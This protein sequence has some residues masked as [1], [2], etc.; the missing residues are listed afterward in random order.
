M[1]T[2]QWGTLFFALAVLHTFIAPMFRRAS[3]HF[4]PESFLAELLHLLGEVEVVFGFWAAIFFV[5]G[6]NVP[7]HVHISNV[8]ILGLLIPVS[9]FEAQFEHMR[10]KVNDLKAQIESVRE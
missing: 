1:T 3:H 5:Q 4:A 7:V 9:H 2:E 8:Q 10:V 6:Q